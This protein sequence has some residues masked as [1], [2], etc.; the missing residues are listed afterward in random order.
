MGIRL[1]SSTGYAGFLH[2]PQGSVMVVR[3]LSLVLAMVASLWLASPAQ[4]VDIIIVSS[5][6]GV[7]GNTYRFDIEVSLDEERSLQKIDL[8]VYKPNDR[9]RYEAKCLNLPLSTGFKSYTYTETGGGEFNVAAAGYGR[10]I[11][12]TVDWMPPVRWVAG[13]YRIEIVLRWVGNLVFTR[14]SVFILVAPGPVSGASPT[15]FS[16]SI[17]SNSGYFTQPVNLYSRNGELM[18]GIKQGTRG[19]T[20]I[21][22]QPITSIIMTPTTIPYSPPAG[23]TI[24]GAS[25]DLAPSRATFSPPITLSISYDP[26]KLPTGA[27]EQN[28]AIAYYDTDRVQWV[29]PEGS[30]VDPAT[31]TVTVD[32]SH[33]MPFTVITYQ[34]PTPSPTPTPKPTPAPTATAP[35]T[36]TPAPKPTPPTPAPKP[37]PTPAPTP[38]Q[39]MPPGFYPE[40]S[41]NW[42]VIGMIAVIALL[43][44]LGIALIVWWVV[45][46][47]AAT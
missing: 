27:V 7:M 23:S 5:N 30:V 44:I 3:A 31:R 33:F 47:R 17:I 24:V 29:V 32:I 16:S 43:A 46:E 45:R 1:W 35:A 22:G 36:P 20:A 9:T 12:Y 21:T 11:N 34:R 14:S 19:K 13:E 4:A 10:I 42:G 18:L 40:P 8:Y 41:T 37:T 28:L 25:Y 15:V 26:A 39:E 6:A 2:R 38:A